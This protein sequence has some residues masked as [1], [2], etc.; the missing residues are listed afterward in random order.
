MIEEKWFLVIASVLALDIIS[1]LINDLV[2]KALIE[3]PQEVHRDDANELKIPVLIFV[4]FC[5]LCIIQLLNIWFSFY[6]YAHINSQWFKSE[7]KD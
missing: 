5:N 6:K 4:L 2:F 7:K 3:A 1:L